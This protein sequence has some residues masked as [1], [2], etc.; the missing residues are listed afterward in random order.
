MLRKNLSSSRLARVGVFG[1]LAVTSAVI[2]TTDAAEARRH[3][4]HYAHPRVQRDVSESSSPKFASIIVDGN[5]GSVLQ[6][7]SPD[8]IRHPASLTKIMTLYLLFER[9]E[10]GKLKLDTEMP[11][12]QHAAD[13]DPTKLN[14][15]AGQTIRVEDAIKGLVTRSANDAAVVIAEAIGGDEDDFA[16][17]MTRKARS[18]GMSRT[19]YRNANGLP[20]DEQVTTARDQATLG[21][22]IQ[23]RFPRYYRYFATSTFNWRGQ[24]IR[25]H[26]HLLGNVEGVDGI[27]TGY[28]RAS[29]F[30][31]VTSMRRGN[32]HLIGVVLGGRSG[33][34]RD[35]IMRNLLAEN[36]DKAAT[37][38]TVVAV[39]ERNGSD[40]AAEVADASDTP[41]RSAPQVQAAPAPEA[42]P[43]RLAA[44]LSTLAAAT[45]AVPPA[46]PRSEAN[47]PEVRSTESKIEP[48][49]L[50]NGVISSQHLSIIPGSSEPMK[51]VR[52]KTVQV[53][54]GTVK[55]A[56]AAPAQ[57]APQV[58]STIASRS[59]VA[60]TS[61]AV[62]ARAD[63]INKPE[64]ASQPEAPKAE[65]ARTELPRQPAGFG[66]G[67]GI[68]GVL[69]AA[70]AA[71]PAPAATKLA[72]ADP[73]LQPVQMS[74][75]AKPVVTH[76]GWIVQVGALESE[77][78]AQQRIDAARSSARGL[79]SKAD[80]FTEPVVAKDNRKLYRARFAGLDRDQAEAVC[81]T[82]KRA[83]ISCMTVR[84]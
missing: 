33:G 50:T 34:S 16:Q 73:A 69:P 29:G 7:T 48:A 18:L 64:V 71:A 43:S 12:S 49:P 68:L 32:R 5:S 10:S 3:R 65:I 79:L 45:A 58:T 11:V 23:E 83:D 27:K 13:Q 56:S 39:T 67:N 60:E 21:R 8:G 9:L 77:N 22:A 61:G 80:P 72:S 25:N 76:S 52:V 2:F 4:R 35:A 81:R 17:M 59:D 26:N 46:Q 47:K 63:L 75:T 62:V 24:S 31:L 15:R 57:I 37:T 30:N 78:E 70:A 36:L 6:A 19:V 1:L 20:N 55:V 74:T 28:T 42:A 53:K 38:H 41:A 82:L 14:L 54:A 66:T 51:P 44:R 40:A 84:N